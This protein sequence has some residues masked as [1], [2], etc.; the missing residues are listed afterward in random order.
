MASPVRLSGLVR[1]FPTA[2]RA[3]VDRLDLE[4][5]TGEVLCLVGPSGCGKS[6]TLRLVAGL[7]TPDEGTVHIGTR[8]MNG[9]P[10]QARD[11]AMVFQGF[12]LYPH[13]TVREIIAFPLKM[14]RVP[15]A[16]REEAVLRTARLLGIE[17]L[18]A[19]RPGQ[20]SG[21]EQQRVAMGRAL[22]RQPEVFLFDEPLSN[23]D[24]ALRAELRIELARLLGQL[25]STALY[26]THDQTEAMTLGHRIA[27]MRLGRIEQIDTPRRIYESPASAFVAAFFGSPPMNLCELEVR[28]HTA[29]LGSLQ[30][31]CP[32]RGPKLVAGIRPEHLLVGA[33]ASGSGLPCTEADV[34]VVELHGAETHIELGVADH[35]LRARVPGFDAPAVRTGVP[36]AIPRQHLCWFDAVTRQAIQ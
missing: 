24:A 3:A 21:G 2:E 18:L 19:R 5:S 8:N 1:H 28:D 12:A 29:R 11:V 14:R 32:D 27:V 16:L 20:L 36:V 13:M 33:A 10:P 7:E 6:T 15:R 4:I 31:E 25:E 9:V 22:V 23:L 35:V 26:V 34:R 17:Q 30:L